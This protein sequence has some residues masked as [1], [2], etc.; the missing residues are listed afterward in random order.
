M[1]KHR[2]ASWSQIDL[3]KIAEND[4]LLACLILLTRYYQNPFS[5]R[6]LIARLPLKEDKLSLDIFPRAAARAGLDAEVKQI[7]LQD[8]DDSQLPLVL[9]KNDNSAILLILN[10]DGKKAILDPQHP[11]I[12]TDFDDFSGELSDSVIFVEQQFK[13]TQRSHETLK[14]QAK[15]WFW[16][17]MIKSWPLYSEVLL[18]SFLV[19]LFALVIPLFTMNV[20]DRV[21]PNHAIDTM[22][23]LASGV[24]LVFIFDTLLKALRSYF[25]DIANKN[26]DI[27]L[28]STIF[29]QVLGLSMSNRP[30]SVGSLANTVQSFEIF[31]DFIT[32]STMTVIIDLPFS[33][34]FLVVIYM[35]GGKLFW[36]PFT[37]IPFIFVIGLL[38][39][40]PLIQLTRK[41]YQFSAEKQ[42]TLF[43][44]LAS[45]E[46]IKT[47]GAE[48]KLQ[49]RWEKIIDEAAKNMMKLRFVA[50]SSISITNLAQQ[51]STILVVIV[52]VY[53][54]ANGDLTTGGLV[55]CTILA[56][57]ALAPMAQ[58]STLFTRYFQSVNALESLNKI[59]QLE[60]DIH[61]ESRYLHRPVLKGDME[62][63]QVN[64]HYPGDDIKVLQQI[65]FKVKA[66]ERVGVIGRVGS[67]KST[68]GKLILKLYLPTEGT[69]LM[70]GTDYKQINPDDLRQQ[71]GYVPQDVILFYGT[72]RENICVGAPFINDND[73]INAAELTGVTQFTNHHP[74]GFDRP[75]G[76]KG[77]DLSGGQRQAIAIA[78]A[79]LTSPNI[80]VMDEPTSSMDDNNERLIKKNLNEYLSDHRTL[81]LITH[82]ISMLEL[83][84]RLIVLENGKIIADGPKESVLNALRSGVTIRS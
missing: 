3:S 77:A 12:I 34:I 83:V 8:I 33:F 53:M 78:R 42:A 75:V 80:L 4:S 52:G 29:Q 70:D 76:E 1:S 49:S 82:K 64:F 25:L 6:S 69:I 18:A 43:E 56:G 22:W 63:K 31:R 81:V 19:N 55:A 62:F 46:A 26:T 7:S 41:S 17:V 37:V 58:V 72:I 30:R 36:I 9:I 39:Q 21:V 48:S 27:E 60:T 51:I 16:S 5:A 24:A 79:I 68:M 54:I 15:D 28:S 57:R 38:L 32:S 2:K 71:I 84:N 66:G 65:S 11:G 50:N 45:I 67:G 44:S 73:L 59:M 61:D 35:I 74:K 23:V 20:Y 10:D 47:S 14:T 13:H 40:W